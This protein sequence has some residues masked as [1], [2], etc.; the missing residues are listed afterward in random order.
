MYVIFHLKEKGQD[1]LNSLMADDEVSRLSISSRDGG[2][3]S[4]EYTGLLVLIEGNDKVVERAVEIVADRGKRL[5]EDKASEVY[6]RIKGES[7]NADQ[8]VGFLFGG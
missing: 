4:D 6:G 8:G 5:V 1:V 3:I 7:E 2:K